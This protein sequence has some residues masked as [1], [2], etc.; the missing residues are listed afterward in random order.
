MNQPAFLVAMIAGVSGILAAVVT[1]LVARRQTSG[2]IGTSDAATLW[3]E[4]QAMRKELRDEVLLLRNDVQ[5]LRTEIRGLKSE[6]D[7]LRLR[8]GHYEGDE[9]HKSG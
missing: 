5:D 8:L 4:S 2:K 9:D 3:A 7:R 6:I 1:Y